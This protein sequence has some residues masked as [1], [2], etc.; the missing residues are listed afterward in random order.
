MIVEEFDQT[1]IF[2]ATRNMTE[3]YNLI[4]SG[5]IL[6]KSD[7]E[8]EEPITLE[9]ENIICGRISNDST[10]Q[11]YVRKINVEEEATWY[12]RAYLIYKNLKVL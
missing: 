2:T 4:E 6:L 11:F 10:D 5:V 1:I 12:G 7:A 9:T 8:L 3:G